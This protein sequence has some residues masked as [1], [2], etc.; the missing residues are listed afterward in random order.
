M[1]EEGLVK[2]D[3]RNLPKIDGIMIA[4]FFSQNPLFRSSEIRGVKTER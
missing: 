2:A 4:E 1:T 3:S